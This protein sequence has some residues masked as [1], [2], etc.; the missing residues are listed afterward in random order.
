MPM[1]AHNTYVTSS[2][3]VMVVL[4]T[5]ADPVPDAEH[6]AAPGTAPGSTVRVKES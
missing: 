4:V 5:A 2:V 6:P 3:P 1:A